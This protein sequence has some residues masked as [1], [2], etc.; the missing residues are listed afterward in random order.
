MD[1]LRVACL[2]NTLPAPDATEAT[3]H[4]VMKIRFRVESRTGR[5]LS[6]T[7]LGWERVQH[8]P[9]FGVAFAFVQLAVA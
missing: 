6:A 3:F 9:S 5:E 1:D 2:I 7:W 4:D 8:W